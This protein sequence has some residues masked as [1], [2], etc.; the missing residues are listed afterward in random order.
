[1]VRSPKEKIVDRLL[2]LYVVDRCETE[3]G[4]TNI[5]ET[6][7]HKLI[8]YSEKTLNEHK[9]KA[10]NYRFIKLLYPTYSEELRKD[11]NEL[12][13]LDFLDGMY[14]CASQKARVVLQDFHQVF[15]NNLEI[16]DLIDS[17]VDKYAPLETEYL[18]RKTKHLP[19]RHGTIDDLKKGTPLVYPLTTSR[20]RCFFQISEEDFEDLA[21]CLSSKISKGIEQ[22]FDELRRGKRLSHAEVFG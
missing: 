11:L 12:A 6:K 22:A 8:F 1:M 4:I 17:Q 14:F 7:M 15:R 2:D 19:W 18:V 20:A 13:Q 10:L 5:S 16:M 3:H 21:I 9:C